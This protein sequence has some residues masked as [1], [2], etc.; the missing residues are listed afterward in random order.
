MGRAAVVATSHQRPLAG[1]GPAGREGATKGV[2]GVWD[3]V[4][5]GH[6]ASQPSSRPAPALWRGSKPAAAAARVR[7]LAGGWKGRTGAGWERGGERWARALFKSGASYA[8]GPAAAAAAAAAAHHCGY[9][10]GAGGSK[11]RREQEGGSS[12]SLPC[13]RVCRLLGGCL[14]L[15]SSGRLRGRRPG[16][17]WAGWCRRRAAGR[18]RPRCTRTPG[19]AMP[20]SPAREGGQ[21]NVLPL[22][23]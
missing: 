13:D 2:W 17:S 9:T 10:S 20:T 6:R 14:C 23:A 8:P 18:P 7:G 19:Q 11:R 3:F 21:Q 12:L 15:G 22:R 16:R 5:G 1:K 4:G